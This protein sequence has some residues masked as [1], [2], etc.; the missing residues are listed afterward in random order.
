[1]KNLIENKV[2]YLKDIYLPSLPNNFK[3]EYSLDCNDSELTFL[4]DGLEVGGDLIIGNA[5]IED[6]PEDLIVCG[7]LIML[8]RTLLIPES[9]II[10][11]KIIT[12]NGNIIPN[13]T[14]KNHYIKNQ[15][16]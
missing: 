15:K 10:G 4:P 2:M 16:F 6:L 11:G 5:Y 7:N 14:N 3:T 12:K 9:A 8:Y 13:N 1:M